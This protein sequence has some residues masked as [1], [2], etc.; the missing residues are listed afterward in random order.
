[1]RDEGREAAR[2]WRDSPRQAVSNPASHLSHYV[3]LMPRRSII[4]ALIAVATI[5]LFIRLGIWQLHRL[6]ERRALNARLSGRLNVAPVSL[7]RLPADTAEAH[8]RRV[9]VSGTFDFD[10]Q[11]VLAGRAWEGSPGVHILTPMKI[12]GS[13]KA[14]LVNR[15]WVYSPDA[16]TV[17]LQRWREPA[18]AT[19]EGYVE[20]FSTG[21]PGAARFTSNPRVW[22]R[23]D[24][25]QL[26]TL[27]P[28]PI[29]P[30]Y[31]VALPQ[32]TQPSETPVRLFLPELDEGPHLS[33]AIQWFSFAAIALYGVSY[34]IW[35]DLRARR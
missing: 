22:R 11:I 7:D 16:V 25:T 13:N 26:G 20:E 32:G 34:L 28:Y 35:Q 3:S 4:A 23:L 17:D 31:V 29:E 18:R 8:Y 10:N 12:D 1:M 24:G 19:I 6:A 5:A 21:G 30:Y 27:F 2:A 15:G 14:V 9:R 33:Y